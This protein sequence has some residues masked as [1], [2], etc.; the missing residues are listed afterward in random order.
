MKVTDVIRHFGG[1]PERG[2]VARTAKVFN[3]NPSAVSKWLLTEHVPVDVALIAD[4]LS[5]GVLQFDK[6]HYQAE[7]LKKI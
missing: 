1:E 2:A 7:L 3:R 4:K 5:G 6:E